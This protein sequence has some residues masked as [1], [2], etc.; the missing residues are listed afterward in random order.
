MPSVVQT[1]ASIT[2]CCVTGELASR[3]FRDG[4]A[5]G[6]VVRH[7]I[8]GAAKLASCPGRDLVVEQ[9]FAVVARHRPGSL[10]SPS[11]S[12]AAI[13]RASRGQLSAWPGSSS[14]GPLHGPWSLTVP[15]QVGQVQVNVRP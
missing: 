12:H 1:P 7:T 13:V 5:Y 10:S 15:W 14:A 3:L 6:H 2:T 9:L 11:A 4:D 8:E